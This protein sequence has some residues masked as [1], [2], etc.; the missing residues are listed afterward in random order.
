MKIV[1]HPAPK[2]LTKQAPVLG[3]VAAGLLVVVLLLQL[4]GLSKVLSGLGTQFDGHDG[5][6]IAVAVIALLSELAALPF[7]L[8]L[9]LSYLASI[10]SGVMAVIAPWVWVLVA[11][12]SVGGDTT[13][14]AAQFGIVSGLNIGW[15]LLAVNVLWLVFN[16]YSVQ[17]LN[18]E[19]VW[20]SATGLKPRSEIKKENHKK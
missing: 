16:F 11:V 3:L 12:W 8:R 20:Y 10:S 17:Q 6:A 4:I 18:I 5:W 14:A 15:G 9:K 7:L 2:P 19:K 1:A 13:F